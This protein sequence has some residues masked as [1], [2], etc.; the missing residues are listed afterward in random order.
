MKLITKTNK[1]YIIVST[2]I[3]FVAG[4]LLFFTLKYTVN[5]EV[6]ERLSENISRISNQIGSNNQLIELYPVI[7]IQQNYNGNITKETIKDTLIIN[8]DHEDEIYREVSDVVNIHQQK[9]LITV[10]QSL[11]ETDDYLYSIGITIAIVFILLIVLMSITL[12]VNSK[13]IWSD[14]YQN[15]E[16]LKNYSLDDNEQLSLKNS[17]IDE[18][19]ELN[20]VVLKLTDKIQSDYKSLKEFTEDASHEIQ[21]PLAIILSKLDFVIQKDT[22]NEDNL[23]D[24]MKVYAAAKRLSKLNQSLILL[25]KIQN[26]QF[27]K[28]EN[29]DLNQLIKNQLDANEELILFK[30]LNVK[31]NSEQSIKL[32]ANAGL[33]EI[34]LA[35]LINNAIKYTIEGKDI[36]INL[37]A[38]ELEIKNFSHPIKVNPNQFFNRFYKNNAQSNSLGLGLAI[39]HKICENYHWKIQYTTQNE[40]HII[41]INFLGN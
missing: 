9:Y 29:L 35:N 34:L 36:L 4:V 32:K 39:V 1:I 2:I 26:K 13:K 3:F 6:N 37:K 12:K 11:M 23:A 28:S 10:R 8:N 41:Q 18:F 33:I 24:I 21:T 7:E 19:N 22:L 16:I 14:F 15:L 17:N 31:L 40:W 5:D 20:N 27:S 30:K 25:T 38:N